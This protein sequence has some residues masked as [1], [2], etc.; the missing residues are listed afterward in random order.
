MSLPTTYYGQRAIRYTHKIL[1]PI[2]DNKPEA[3]LRDWPFRSTKCV[4]RTRSEAGV[5][6]FKE[7]R[8]IQRLADAAKALQ[9]RCGHCQEY[10]AVVFDYLIREKCPHRVEYAHYEKPGDHAFVILGRSHTSKLNM[11]FTWGIESVIVDAWKGYIVR[12]GSY[13]FEI[14]NPIRASDFNGN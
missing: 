12:P 9:N 13:L 1:G 14:T 4:E 3:K 6:N 7:I 2:A 10:A 8:D 5:E 11:P